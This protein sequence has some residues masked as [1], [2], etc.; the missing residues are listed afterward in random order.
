MGGFRFLDFRG[1]GLSVSAE[2][3]AE[4]LSGTQKLLRPSAPRA[5][6]A[7]G[8]AWP[9][10]RQ[11][12]CALSARRSLPCG[13]GGVFPR[14]ILQH[15]SQGSSWA[16]TPRTMDGGTSETAGPQMSDLASLRL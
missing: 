4:L 13:F 9:A 10:L 6:P 15:S 11:P 12:G 14:S 8:A 7:L 16:Q 5:S 3:V 2:V 1:F